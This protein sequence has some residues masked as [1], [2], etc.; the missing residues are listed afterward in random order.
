MTELI[1]CKMLRKITIELDS[2]TIKRLQAGKKVKLDR[3]SA[4]SDSNA[5]EVEIYSSDAY[6]GDDE[7]E[8]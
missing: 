3:V 8:D 6:V 2:N 5:F 4:D 7:L 1:S